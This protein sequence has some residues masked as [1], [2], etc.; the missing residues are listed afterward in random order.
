MTAGALRE[1]A[2]VLRAEGLSKRFGGLHAVQNVSFT[3]SAG[4]ILAVIGPNGAGKTTLLNLL[5]GVYRPSSGRLWLLGRDVTDDSM[6]ARCHAGLGRAFQIVRPFPEMTVHEN[7]TVGALFG[8]PG[9]SLPA[10]RERAYDLLER[11]GLAAH[12]DKA[13]HELTL[14]QDKRLEVA[15]ALATEPRV[16]LLDEVMA[17]LRPAEA[18]EAVALVRSVRDSGVSVLFIEHIMPVVRD[19]ADRVVVMD[20]GQVIAQGTYREVTANPQV[21]AAY[22]GTEEGLHA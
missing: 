4:E 9:V 3:H 21:V 6:E 19:L 8:K 5:S 7:V 2:P 13:A 18:Q 12:A 11:T 17:G 22:L 14:L 20:Q 10:A 16:L 15:R 1:S